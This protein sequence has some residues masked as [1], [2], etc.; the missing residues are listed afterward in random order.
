MKPRKIPLRQCIGCGARK[1]KRELIRIV[2]LPEGDIHI[3]TS[4]KK[5]GRGAYICNSAA[6]LEAARKKHALNRAFKADVSD[7]VFEQLEKELEKIADES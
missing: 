3:D 5:N 7:S 4:G 2:K 6:C 1:E